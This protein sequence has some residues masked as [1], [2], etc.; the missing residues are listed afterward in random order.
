MYNGDGTSK[1]LKINFREPSITGHAYRKYYRGSR[2]Y[3]FFNFNVISV[4]LI[5]NTID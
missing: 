2:I 3:G 5:S 4:I 1:N